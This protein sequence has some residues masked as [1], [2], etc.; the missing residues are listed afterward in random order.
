[1]S[2]LVCVTV[3]IYDA[4]SC[5]Q[6]CH[7]FREH[8]AT[9]IQLRLTREDCYWGTG[10]LHDGCCVC[11]T[12]LMHSNYQGSVFALSNHYHLLI[13]TLMMSRIRHE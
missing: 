13:T 5:Y 7:M 1:M 9:H 4:P 12:N 10:V 6:T 11:S 2:R 3:M 8:H